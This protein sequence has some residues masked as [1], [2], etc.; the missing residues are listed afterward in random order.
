MSL[1]KRIGK[2]EIVRKI[3]TG[4]MAEIY[5][6]Q[7]SG[8]EGFTK[9]LVIKRIHSHLCGN[10]EFIS[11]FIHEAR[12]AAQLN[13]P[14]IVHVHDF[15]EVGGAYFIAM[16]YIEG[17]DLKSIYRKIISCRQLIPIPVCAFIIHELCSALHY[18]HNLRDSTNNPLGIVHR[19]IS[20]QNVLISNAGEVKLT[21]F[22]IA[23]V[24]R[25]DKPAETNTLKGKIAY[26]S[27][28]QSR[29]LE[30]D[31]RSDIF[32]LGVVLFEI[33]V[34]QRLFYGKTDLA[35]L[36]RVR[37]AVIPVP[38]EIDP[39]IPAD[40]DRILLKA[41]AK[42]LEHRYQ[43]ASDM[44]KDLMAFVLNNKCVNM[45]MDL[46]DLVTALFPDD[47]SAADP[48][49]DFNLGR[50]VPERRLKSVLKQSTVTVKGLTE[51]PKATT[52]GDGNSAA[53]GVLLAQP[54]SEMSPIEVEDIIER[55][56]TDRAR[57]VPV[58]EPLPEHL[59]SRS[60]LAGL[61]SY[62]PSTMLI[63]GTLIAVILLYWFGVTEKVLN[64]ISPPT[65]NLIVTSNVEGTT[66][67]LDG[68]EVGVATTNRPLLLSDIHAGNLRITGEK[69]NYRSDPKLIELK[70]GEHVG[71]VINMVPIQ[72][73]LVVRT[74][75]RAA[76]IHIDGKFVGK[77]EIALQDD[78]WEFVTDTIAVGKHH[79]L[80]SDSGLPY[81]WQEITVRDDEA[82]IVE[83]KL[84][85]VAMTRI[86]KL[87]CDQPN[88]DIAIDGKV[89]G[90]T[91]GN[92]LFY[93]FLKN[94]EYTVEVSKSGFKKFKDHVEITK[95]ANAELTVQLL[96]SSATGNL[97]IMSDPGARII[98]DGQEVGGVPA[99]G[100][101]TLH[102][103]AKGSHDVV[104]KK[105][106]FTDYGTVIDVLQGRTVKVTAKLQIS[107]QSNTLTLTIITKPPGAL[108][109][110]DNHD[111]KPAP[112][113]FSKIRPGK[114]TV[115]I[116]MDG[117]KIWSKT[118]DLRQRR[119]LVINLDRL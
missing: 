39:S 22:G 21:D 16:E 106:G 81:Q 56:S 70:P 96:P 95:T 62:I 84:M 107:A 5:L 2:Y 87:V 54:E 91:D 99:N 17:K 110:L 74:N 11:M 83:I 89:I 97:R 53:Q 49:N 24:R 59:A 19:D 60:Q 105:S 63:G 82:T 34:G 28:E 113:I 41:L 38:S 111:A 64:L 3:A 7:H 86:L 114:H 1:P 93:T 12:L 61:K 77:A 14:N 15:G 37:D 40:L 90:R 9:Q 67:L 73:A 100:E 4:G 88:A 117:Y 79:L 32:S 43:D 50:P 109:L 8:P 116:T 104:L 44:G 101:V 35:T 13:H 80:V 112:A 108:V 69:P 103:I 98:L 78:Q 115:T 71:V 94:G 72:Q 68:E 42:D 51:E 52:K 29:G 102:K 46:G 119:E 47:D 58:D 92:G 23:K 36:E 85:S 33:L 55:P 57:R 65:G 25:D 76:N 31:G 18:A 45:S 27:P 20:P 30:V 48:C 118:I 75:V 10:D 66:V 6:A 26:M